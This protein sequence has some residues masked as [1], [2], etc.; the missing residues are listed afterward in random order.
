MNNVKVNIENFDENSHS[1]IVSFSGI[2]NDVEY[3]TPS[4]A[5]QTYNFNSSDTSEIINQLAILGSTYLIQEKS[6]QESLK[7]V[8]DFKNMVGT[9]VEVNV[10]SI[11]PQ[12]QSF[13]NDLVDNL[14]VIV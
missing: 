10:P 9:S 4:Y 13:N 12:P 11:A 6:K 3:R 1:V 5:F 2:E 14:E 7:F 8:N